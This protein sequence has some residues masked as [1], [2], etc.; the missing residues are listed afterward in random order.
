MD[1]NKELGKVNKE[2][3]AL[4]NKVEKLIVAIGKLE[5]SKPKTVKVKAAKKASVK[6]PATKSKAVKK[7]PAKKAAT[8]KKTAKKAPAKKQT[9]EKTQKLSAIETVL[10]IINGSEMGVNTAELMKQTGFNAKK[11]HN[12]VFKLKKQGKIKAEKKGVYVKA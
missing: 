9:T 7:A 4:A 5:K 1:I 11:V 12:N 6:K 3:K 2:I 8:K 10:A